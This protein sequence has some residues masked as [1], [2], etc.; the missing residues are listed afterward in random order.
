[1]FTRSR[2]L[3]L[4]HRKLT[5]RFIAHKFVVGHRLPYINTPSTSRDKCSRPSPCI[6][7]NANQRTKKNGGS[8]G[9]KSK[10]KKKRGKPGNKA[11]WVDQSA[12]CK[13]QIVQSAQE[14]PY[15]GKLSREKTFANFEVL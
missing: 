15:S 1:M 3:D 2:A 14:V 12:K 10:N 7:L 4:N 11:T 8:L 6:I 5:L 13:V 9:C